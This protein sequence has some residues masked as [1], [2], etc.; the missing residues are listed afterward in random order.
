IGVGKT[1]LA[2]YLKQELQAEL[3]LEVFEEN[4]F[5]KKFYD[6]RDCYALQT[7]LFFL[8]SRYKQHKALR[9]DGSVLV[10]DYIFA[11]NDLFARFTLTG[12]EHTLYQ[13]MSVALASQLATPTLVV[14]LKASLNVLMDRIAHRGRE[15]EQG[16]DMREYM[17]SL[18]H[19]YDTFFADYDASPVLVLNT[20][21]I[22]IVEDLDARG[23]IIKQVT[24]QFRQILEEQPTQV[25][26]F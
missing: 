16:V 17:D 7:Q 8:M 10:S 6:N 12:E 18:V 20:D 22:N 13:E 15:Y 25:P 9:Q 21:N 26:L 4:P 24:A 1:T 14:V 5:L 23:A 19:Q 3:M 11:K 2:S